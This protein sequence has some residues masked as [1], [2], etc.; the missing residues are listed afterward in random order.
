V[1][2]AE[3]VGEPGDREAL[4]AAGG[5]LDQVALAR[6][7]AAGIAHQAAHGIELLVAGK[8][9][10]A[11][12]GLAALVVFV[13]HLVDELPHQIK[14]AGGRPDL[15]PEVGG[16]V[17][18]TG[19]WNRRVAGTAETPLVEGKEAGFRL[20][21][22]G[23]HIDQFGIHGEVTQ[24]A[25]VGE[26]WFA[27]ITGGL[28][29]ADRV[30]DVLAGE[31]ILEFGGEQGDTVEKEHQIEAVLVAGAVA[32]LAHHGEEVGGMEP[33]RFRVEA[34]GGLEVGEAELAAGILDPL[35]QHI[36]SAAAFDF[37]GHTP[38]ELLPHS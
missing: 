4:A 18:G 12:A 1:E 38:E 35:A 34:A 29:L 31:G 28:V 21:Q 20:R 10:K 23:G 24:T 33:L 19:G 16:G 14:H 32:E 7:T 6:A 5:V 25:C 3:L 30:F 27:G 11:F 9:Q 37:R 13:F 17:T 26:E 36:E 15:L 22:L 2:G 8:D